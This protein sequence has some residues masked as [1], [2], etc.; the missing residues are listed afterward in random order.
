[1]L[2][3]IPARLR[4]SAI[5]DEQATITGAATL[6]E[7]LC[8][9][10]GVEDLS[11]CD[12]LDVGCGVKFTQAILNHDI[13]IKSY[14]GVD[15]YREMV[16]FLRSN[17]DDPRFEYH[18]VDV[19]NDLYN[20]GAPP[21]AVG[22]DLGLGDRTFDVICLYSVFTHLPPSDYVTMLKLVRR[23][24]RPDGRLVYTLFIDELTERGHGLMDY[25]QRTLSQ[26]RNDHAPNAAADAQR[27]VLPF[28]DLD[29]N[30]PLMYALYSR[31][32]AHELIEGTGWEP[33][34]M[35]PPTEH[36]QHVFVCRPL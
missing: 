6:L 17:V 8:D 26:G 15:V 27:Q 30:R 34:R 5:T 22:S 23:H 2:T 32:H 12:V 33:L 7:Q 28:R 29:P 10:V 4:R 21:M 9:L 24:S 3:N 1:V 13:P 35:V 14:T 18:H 19:R 20:P 25:L 16:E 36:A 31:E 11:R